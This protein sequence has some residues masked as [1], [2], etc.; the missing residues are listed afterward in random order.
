MAPVAEKNQ[1]IPDSVARYVHESRRNPFFNGKPRVFGITRDEME[2]KRILTTTEDD[3]FNEIVQILASNGYDDI[4]VDPK[5]FIYA[6]GDI[7]IG[8]S[9]HLDTVFSALPEAIYMIEESGY[10]F[11]VDIKNNERKYI[12]LGADDR[13]GVYILLKIIEAGYKPGVIITRLEEKGDQGARK[14]VETIKD[15]PDFKYIICLDR[16]GTN[17]AVFYRDENTDFQKYITE[18]FGFKEDHGTVSDISV[19]CPSWKISGVNLSVG[20]E[21]AHSPI[22][23]LNIPIVTGMVARV[24]AMLENPPAE[25]FHYI[26][27]PYTCKPREKRKTKAP[28]KYSKKIIDEDLRFKENLLIHAVATFNDLMA[29][30]IIDSIQIKSKKDGSGKALVTV[31]W[32]GQK[33]PVNI[34][35]FILTKSFQDKIVEKKGEYNGRAIMEWLKQT[36]LALEK[37]IGFADALSRQLS[38]K[39]AMKTP[40]KKP[41]DEEKA[42][43]TAVDLINTIKR[44]PFVKYV[45]IYINHSSET[46][47]VMV[48]FKNGTVCYLDACSNKRYFVD[49]INKIINETHE[50]KIKDNFISMTRIVENWIENHSGFGEKLRARV[51][52]TS[53]K[54]NGSKE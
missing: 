20:Y 46:A 17:D 34:Y 4:I 38:G 27:T 32:H 28:T 31:D 29:M 1:E 30:N 51:K 37:Y 42:L 52:A 7:P 49:Q 15:I 2:I 43:L 48:Y 45:K 3:L 19:L 33:I 23:M 54:D 5:F 9:V 44:L 41:F 40:A 12:G 8:I 25:Q 10:A 21:Y 14:A 22:E 26:I 47:H 36:E 16:K 24:I 39:P 13:A 53:K 11:T 6:K 50:V 18:T 35:D